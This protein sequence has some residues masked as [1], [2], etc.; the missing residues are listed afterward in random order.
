MSNFLRARLLKADPKSD[1]PRTMRRSRKAAKARRGA[2]ATKT[3]VCLMCNRPFE[4]AWAG[5]RICRKCKSTDTY[6]SGA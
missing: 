3:R 2:T 4:S 5:E 1:P 6:R